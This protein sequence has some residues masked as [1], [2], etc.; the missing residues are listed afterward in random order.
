METVLWEAGLPQDLPSPSQ[1]LKYEDQE[2]F[3]SRNGKN[4]GYNKM[5]SN[6][7]EC[8]LGGDFTPRFPGVLLLSGA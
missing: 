3:T 5:R 1:P 4:A 2:A 8:T 6:L 7:R